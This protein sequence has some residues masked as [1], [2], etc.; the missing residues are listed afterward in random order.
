MK[1][2]FIKMLEMSPEFAPEPSPAI[3]PEMIKSTFEALESRGMVHYTSGGIYV[4]TEEGWKL[5]METRPE[6]EQIFARGH[7]KV[8]ATNREMIKITRGEILEKE[9]DATIAVKSDKACK[10]LKDEFKAALKRAKKVEIVIESE[11]VSDKI[12]AYGSPAL[13][14]SSMEEIIIRKDSDIDGRTLAILADKSANELNQE[15][16]ERLRKLDAVVKIGL[17]IKP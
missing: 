4:P 1:S 5:L 3:T 9:L 8:L 17:E 2:N 7:P 12:V 13:K 6:K 10:D 14:L 16:V 11:G 15:L